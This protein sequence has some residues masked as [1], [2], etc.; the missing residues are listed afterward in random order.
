MNRKPNV[1]SKRRL[2][3]GEEVLTKPLEILRFR[4]D[5]TDAEDDVDAVADEE[6]PFCLKVQ[7][8]RLKSTFEITRDATSQSAP[9]D[10]ENQNPFHLASL[11]NLKSLT[12]SKSS[13]DESKFQSQTESK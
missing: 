8:S 1:R 12:A 3:R 6:H 13:R 10:H 5:L 11:K 2:E 4:L 9:F 7:K